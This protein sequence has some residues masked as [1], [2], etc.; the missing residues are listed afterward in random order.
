MEIGKILNLKKKKVSSTNF[1]K[2]GCG[3]WGWGYGGQIL[4]I[5]KLRGVI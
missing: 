4:Y 3:G 2:F 5:T 1:A